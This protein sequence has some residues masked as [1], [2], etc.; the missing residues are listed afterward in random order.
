MAG[1]D[2]TRDAFETQHHPS[3]SRRIVVSI[4]SEITSGCSCGRSGSNLTRLHYTAATSLL[5]GGH[6]HRHAPESIIVYPNGYILIHLRD[7]TAC[8]LT[9]SLSAGEDCSDAW[10]R[11]WCCV[12]LRGLH[13]QFRARKTQS[14]ALCLLPRN[15]LIR[16]DDYESKSHQRA[17]RQ[18]VVD[19]PGREKFLVQ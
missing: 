1:R 15:L 7:G 14:L 10:F 3:E 6:A 17:G 9:Q 11:I 13:C 18:E 16:A 5:E 19:L 2:E 8:Q 12:G 4:H